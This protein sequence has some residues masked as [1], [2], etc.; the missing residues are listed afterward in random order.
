MG[1]GGALTLWPPSNRAGAMRVL[2]DT[3]H[4]QI[5]GQVIH[6]MWDPAGIVRQS[7]AGLFPEL[8]LMA[9]FYKREQSY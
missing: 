7:T 6:F 5:N 1:S 2:I 9:G 3:V 8:S 4:A